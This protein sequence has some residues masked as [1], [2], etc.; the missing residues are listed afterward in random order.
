MRRLATNQIAEAVRATRSRAAAAVCHCKPL[1]FHELKSRC[2]PEFF[3]VADWRA[4]A[5][6]AA[7]TQAN[8]IPD[9]VRS[10]P[11]TDCST[12]EVLRHTRCNSSNDFPVPP[13]LQASHRAKFFRD[14]CMKYSWTLPR[15]RR[16][17]A[18]SFQHLAKR[19]FRLEKRVLGRRLADFQDR[20]DFGMTEAFHFVK[21]KNVALAAGQLR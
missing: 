1:R 19:F 8:P 7:T 21:Q 4:L 3:V 12:R 16:A 20:G 13:I 9:G 10:P 17:A 15:L 11:R 2:Q 5:R 6:C 18:R 14:R